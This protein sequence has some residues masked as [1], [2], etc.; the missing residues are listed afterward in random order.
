MMGH[1]GDGRIRPMVEADL[2]SVLAWRN[3]PSVRIWMY[4][5][6][7]IS[8][9]EHRTW[10]SKASAD[11]SRILLVYLNHEI[12][13]GF[14]NLKTSYGNNAEWGFY[15]NPNAPKGTGKGMGIATLRYAFE[16]CG[17]HKIH[18]QVLAYN[19][20]S[21]HY[22]LSLGFQREGILRGQHFDGTNYHDVHC[23]GLLATEWRELQTQTNADLSE[24]S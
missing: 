20:R 19:E 13:S 11:S 21:I 7:A 24:K 2:E 9:Q 6:H 22:H 10:F 23:F 5:Q 18:G 15:T 1:T 16:N 14:V 8:P 3:H 12:P 4:T 17:M